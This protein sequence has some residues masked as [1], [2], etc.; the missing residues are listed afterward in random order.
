MH[1]NEGIAVIYYHKGHY[2]VSVMC[3]TPDLF[4]KAVPVP[5]W[6]AFTEQAAV[7]VQE[8]G[9]LCNGQLYYPCPDALVAQD[10]D[11]SV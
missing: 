9:G 5:N 11:Q 6:E 4:L 10:S 8:Q 2:V 7:A 3:R 1:L